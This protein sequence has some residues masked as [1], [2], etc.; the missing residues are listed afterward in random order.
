RAGMVS[1]GM[2][3]ARSRSFNGSRAPNA[4][5]L[6]NAPPN[7]GSGGWRRL[8]SQP[9][10]PA[11]GSNRSAVRSFSSPVRISPTIVNNRSESPANFRSPNSSFGGFGGSR[12]ASQAAPSA[13]R[14]YGGGGG[15]RG[16]S[17]SGGSPRG[18]GGAPHGNGGGSGPHGG[19]RH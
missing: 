4:G 6:G 17:P 9:G 2:P 16:G 18:G 1:S 15:Y 10:V 8:D 11:Y 13:P 19:P 14:N 5:R 3:L 7:G 12:P